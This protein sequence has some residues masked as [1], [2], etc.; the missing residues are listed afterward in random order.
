MIENAYDIVVTYYSFDLMIYDAFRLSDFS[1]L[2]VAQAWL[3]S[4]SYGKER[5]FTETR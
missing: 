4:K 1:E 3:E 5:R 2:Y